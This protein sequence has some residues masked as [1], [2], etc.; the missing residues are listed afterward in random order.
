MID[1]SDTLILTDL[2][3]T[4]FGKK[5]RLVPRNLEAIERFKAAGGFFTISTG[6]HFANIFKPIPDIKN[7]VNAPI[8]CC[9]GAL[10]YDVR[11]EEILAEDYISYEFGKPVI[12]YL[13]E[14]YPGAAVRA[15]TP[16]G[17]YVDDDALEHSEMLQHD[18][19]TCTPGYYHVVP[20]SEWGQ[21][22]WYKLV[23]REEADKIDAMREEMEA[24]G[25][26]GIR[27]S[28]SG[29]TFF[30][31]MPKG[32]DKATRIEPLRAYA[33]GISGKKIKV[34]CCG[35]Y[36]NDIEMLVAADGGVCPAN[37][38]EKV[39][40]IADYCLCDNETGLIADL[41]EMLEKKENM[42]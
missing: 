38:E 23:I 15:S 21:I 18:V 32:I 35:D 27:F 14:R 17:F 36:E 30:E 12:D 41:I 4:F 20:Y 33:A 19:S 39:K 1:F 25:F 2:D 8:V 40:K 42:S 31:I 29:K 5:S 9:N 7:L 22:G 11:T 13:N 26:E 34:Y 3:G 37:A 6:R 10:L 16:A 28:R 24:H